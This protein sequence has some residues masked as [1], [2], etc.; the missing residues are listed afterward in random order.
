MI[1]CPRGGKCTKSII[2]CNN[3]TLNSLPPQNW[4]IGTGKDGSYN[5]PGIQSEFESSGI[6]ILLVE[7]HSTYQ[8]IQVSFVKFSE[9]CHH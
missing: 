6:I 4:G 5:V 7:W 2:L 9:V 1:T 3:A 8:P